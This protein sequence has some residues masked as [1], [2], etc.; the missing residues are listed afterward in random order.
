MCNVSLTVGSHGSGPTTMTSHYDPKPQSLHSVYPGNLAN[1]TSSTN[2]LA[3]HMHSLYCTCICASKWVVGLF[4]FVSLLWMYRLSTHSPAHSWPVLRQV[5]TQQCCSKAPI[6]THRR[7]HAQTRA[8]SLFYSLL[9]P[10]L[11]KH[12]YIAP[13][14]QSFASINRP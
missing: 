6:H 1:G 13:G 8:Q 12:T 7:T 3:T 11:K 4:S 2:P 5:F 14:P 10:H 9:F